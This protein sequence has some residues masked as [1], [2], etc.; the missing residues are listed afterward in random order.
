MAPRPGDI[1]DEYTLG[2]IVPRR[3]NFMNHMRN[4]LRGIELNSEE[5]FHLVKEMMGRMSIG[6]ATEFFLAILRE[7]GNLIPMDYLRNIIDQSHELRYEDM[8]IKEYYTMNRNLAMKYGGY[9]ESPYDRKVI[10]EDFITEE[11]IE[12]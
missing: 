2:P 4:H 6:S 7:Y 12:L 1:R 3:H 9:Y 8:R 11:D 5:G 10:E